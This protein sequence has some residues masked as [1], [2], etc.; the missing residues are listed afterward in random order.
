MWQIQVLLFELSGIFFP[1]IVD[2]R[3]VGFLDL[4][5]VDVEGQ[6]YCLIGMSGR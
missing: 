2:Q 5:L 1:N 4:E 6:L 3:L